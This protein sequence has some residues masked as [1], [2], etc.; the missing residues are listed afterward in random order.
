[1]GA[2]IQSSNR[3]PLTCLCTSWGP[4]HIHVLLALGRETEHPATLGQHWTVGFL[5]SSYLKLSDVMGF[6]LSTLSPFTASSSDSHLWHDKHLSLLIP[7]DFFFPSVASVL[8]LESSFSVLLLLCCL[9]QVSQ[10]MV[11]YPK[12][13]PSLSRSQR[14]ETEGSLW[15]QATSFELDGWLSTGA[16]DPESDKGD[17]SSLGLLQK[18][19]TFMMDIV[20][21]KVME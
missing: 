12:L 19:E 3:I 6:F 2:V 10:P 9:R 7:C 20:S 5:F 14:G 13:T 18:R 4:A 11:D 1:M 8:L 16:I 21:L 17:S 15:L